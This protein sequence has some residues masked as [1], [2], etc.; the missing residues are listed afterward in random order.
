[1]ALTIDRSD[2]KR[3]LAHHVS[4]DE[5]VV[6]LASV[7]DGAECVGSRIVAV[8]GPVSRRDLGIAEDATDAAVLDAVAAADVNP[9]DEDGEW[10][11]AE[12][13]AGRV[14]YPYGVR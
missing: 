5:Y 12:E 3:A 7:W 8:T 4:G 13:D 2:S 10:L 11:A 14:S 6:T 1:M 9:D